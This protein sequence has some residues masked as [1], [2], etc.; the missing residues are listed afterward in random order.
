MGSA[1]KAVLVQ[2]S[3]LR[4]VGILAPW[5]QRSKPTS[6]EISLAGS[7]HRRA[8]EEFSPR[9]LWTQSGGLVLV[10][11][12]VLSSQY[13]T[14]AKTARASD[15]AFV[16]SSTSMSIQFDLK[17]G[18]WIALVI[19]ISLVF[20][21]P[22]FADKLEAWDAA[23]NLVRVDPR[24][25]ARCGVEPRVELSRW[26]YTYKFSGDSA[27]ARFRGRLVASSCDLRFTVA[28]HL[29]RG[30]WVLHDLSF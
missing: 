19:L 13:S 16:A 1:G 6:D 3:S 5:L 9:V 17:K 8:M 2:A 22:M 15:S 4:L 14:V 12:Q 24:M 7:R 25:I 26:F 20:V 27:Q 18:A 28:V 21:P 10:R 29:E 11:L 30:V 23:K